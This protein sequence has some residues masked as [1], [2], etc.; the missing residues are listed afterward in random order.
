MDNVHQAS[1]NR[2]FQ[3]YMSDNAHQREVNDLRKA[4]LNPILSSTRGAGAST[5]SGS[6]YYCR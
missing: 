4:G 1:R 3:S 2:S 5:P 6:Y